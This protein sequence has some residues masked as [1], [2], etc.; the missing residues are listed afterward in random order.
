[1]ESI[2]SPKF[3]N[4]QH[5]HKSRPGTFWAPS[6]D[7]IQKIKIDDSVKVC[8][9]RERFWITVNEIKKDN[10]DDPFKHEFIGAVDNDLID[11]E[12]YDYG[13]IVKFHGYHIYDFQCRN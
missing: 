9:G 2:L 5:M 13:S 12:E 7:D 4:A 11:T 1:M 10:V 8:N 6:V 3:I